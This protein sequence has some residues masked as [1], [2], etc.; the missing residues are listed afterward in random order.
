[1]AALAARPASA[2][3]GPPAAPAPASTGVAT[4]AASWA[5]SCSVAPAASCSAR[6]RTASAASGEST[7]AS[8]RSTT[9]LTRRWSRSLTSDLWQAAYHLLA[10]LAGDLPDL[11]QRAQDRADRLGH[12]LLDVGDAV[13]VAVG[14]HDMPDLAEVAARHCREEVVLDLVVE[15]A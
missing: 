2:A 5:A 6:S 3:G 4:A 8:S 14:A 15:A 1:I 12:R 13:L 11:V 10:R 7:R 9:R